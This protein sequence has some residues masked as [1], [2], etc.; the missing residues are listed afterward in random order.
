[1][2]LW[3]EGCEAQMQPISGPTIISKAQHVWKALGIMEGDLKL[4]T[5]WLDEFKK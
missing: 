5:G 2:K 4:S 3:V 1:M